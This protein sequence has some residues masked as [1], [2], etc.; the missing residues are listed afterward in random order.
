MATESQTQNA[1]ESK[2]LPPQPSV[3]DGGYDCE[4]LES[5]PSHLP[6]ECYICLSTLR[7][8]FLTS[9]CGHSFCRVCIDRIKSPCPLCN[10]SDFITVPN[11]WLQRSLFTF[12]V[13]CHNHRHGCTWSGE[14]GK[15]EQHLNVRSPGDER[16]RGCAYVLIDC[17]Y[18]CGLRVIRKNIPEHEASCLKRP[19]K[20]QYCNTFQAPFDKIAFHWKT[21]E[22]Y[23][24][25]CPNRCTHVSIP[26]CKLEQHLNEECPKITVKCEMCEKEMTRLSMPGHSCAASKYITYPSQEVEHSSS[27]EASVSEVFSLDSKLN[28]EIQ[29]QQKLR[30]RIRSLEADSGQIHKQIAKLKSECDSEVSVL[31]AELQL[32]HQEMEECEMKISHKESEIAKLREKS[33]RDVA[34]EGDILKKMK[35]EYEKALKQAQET[36]DGSEAKKYQVTLELE[37]V[38]HKYDIKIKELELELERKKTLV[39]EKE[40]EA[41]RK[42]SLLKVLQAQREM[43]R[44]RKEKEIL[45]ETSSREI[46]DLKRRNADLER[47]LQLSQ[48]NQK[49]RT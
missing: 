31:K 48:Q 25:I 35:E 28:L 8:P 15:L 10:S 21:C 32:R 4:F 1:E 47:Q 22:F 11:K 13:S 12:R 7:E 44:V 23:P 41:N 38:K 14:L 16:T 27:D 40:A 18:S 2:T 26:R 29:V 36:R 37:K 3:E 43:D 49:K 9:C 39:A 5:L 17:P 19:Q 45:K 30:E 42:E 33:A 24:I 34:T 20:C 46:E 6:H